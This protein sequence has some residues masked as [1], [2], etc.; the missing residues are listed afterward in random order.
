MV[1]E[2]NKVKSLYF[3]LCFIDISNCSVWHVKGKLNGR[4]RLLSIKEYK[5]E[6]NIHHGSQIV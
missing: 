6:R 3:F 2:L 4:S 5:V 1:H